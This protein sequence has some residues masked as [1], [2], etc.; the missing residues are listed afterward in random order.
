MKTNISLAGLFAV[1]LLFSGCSFGEVKD[2]TI[3][4]ITFTE[5]HEETYT[6]LYT[7]VK[8]D[9]EETLSEFFEDFTAPEKYS[10]DSELSAQLDLEKTGLGKYDFS[11]TSKGKSTSTPPKRPSDITFEDA[12]DIVLEGEIPT[13]FGTIANVNLSTDIAVSDE[14]VGFQIKK[15]SVK[16]PEDKDLVSFA[17]LV[18]NTYVTTFDEI[19][20]QVGL[21]RAEF[22]TIFDEGF[23][24]ASVEKVKKAFEEAS[25]LK[26]QNF[27]SEEN[28]VKKYAVALDKEGIKKFGEEIQ[29]LNPEGMSESELEEF[30]AD[31]D[32]M[33][34]EGFLSL[35]KSDETFFHLEGDLSYAEEEEKVAVN[36]ERNGGEFRLSFTP[37]LTPEEGFSF[38]RTAEKLTITAPDF[39]VDGDIT[40][41]TFSGTISGEGDTANFSFTEEDEN[42][43]GKIGIPSESVSILFEDVKIDA[44]EN[45]SGNMSIT[46]PSFGLVIDIDADISELSSLNVSVPTSGKTLPE[47]MQSVMMISM[48]V[49]QATNPALEGGLPPNDVFVAPGE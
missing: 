27:V 33:E 20:T 41:T 19:L 40:E 12:S 24:N 42:I 45:I 49:M 34:F 6:E 21:S 46:T 16:D 48:E 26:F 9:L 43:S 23:G 30:K 3:D 2:K 4:T 31:I 14:N 32:K 13:P 5:N 15:G 22:D 44:K 11:I 37:E 47:F 7:N 36:V 1:L 18:G 29:A 8:D 17:S 35:K 10:Y 25:F 39:S 28:G 38:E